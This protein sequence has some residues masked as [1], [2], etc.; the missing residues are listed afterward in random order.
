MTR[1]LFSAISSIAMLQQYPPGVHV[2]VGSRYVQDAIV[3][4]VIGQ[5]GAPAVNL[6]ELARCID[7]GEY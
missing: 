4:L 3:A 5:T 1:K 7:D 6:A 2:I